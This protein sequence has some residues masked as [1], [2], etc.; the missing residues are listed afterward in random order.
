VLDGGLDAIKSLPSLPLEDIA[1]SGSSGGYVVGSWM[2]GRFS[3][4]SPL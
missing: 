4:G 1:E 3:I 2:E